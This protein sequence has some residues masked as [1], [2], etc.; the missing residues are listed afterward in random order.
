MD[1]VS[2]TWSGNMVKCNQLLSSSTTVSDE[3]F[4]LTVCQQDI[5]GWISK[6]KAKGQGSSK[7][8][9]RYYENENKEEEEEE[10]NEGG[11]NSQLFE[12]D[13]E[14]ADGDGKNDIEVMLY[15]DL[16]SKISAKRKTEEEGK[17]WD[18]GFQNAIV[19]S[20]TTETNTEV[21]STSSLGSGSH[22]QRSDN[23]RQPK[24]EVEFDDWGGEV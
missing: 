15:Y 19:V 10:D 8:K 1:R 21:A 9:H 12:N 2:K 11:V 5:K 13:A 16:H 22:S 4:A 14:D 20:K 18:L 6:Y 23:V 24:C 7:A 17:S 3:A